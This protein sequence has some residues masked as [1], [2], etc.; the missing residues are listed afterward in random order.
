[1]KINQAQKPTS[2]AAYSGKSDNKSTFKAINTIEIHTKT[3][4]NLINNKELLNN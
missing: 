3:G 1:M 4:F 2:L